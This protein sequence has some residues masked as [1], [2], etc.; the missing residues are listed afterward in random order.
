MHSTP[1]S[2]QAEGPRNCKLMTVKKTKKFIRKSRPKWTD[3]DDG[4]AMTR[5]P[6]QDSKRFGSAFI[7]CGPGS[8]SSKN[9]NTDHD[10]YILLVNYCYKKASFRYLYLSYIF[11]PSI[12][13]KLKIVHQ[14]VLIFFS[15]QANPDH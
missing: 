15:V 10:T 2:V 14:S 8:E 4:R 13:R 3:F 1:K 9:R 12:C 6:W 7:S 5:K 11:I